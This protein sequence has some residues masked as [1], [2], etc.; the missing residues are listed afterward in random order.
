MVLLPNASQ[1][2]PV[3]LIQ[4]TL[5]LITGALYPVKVLSM[6]ITE[7][8]DVSRWSSG[9]RRKRRIS[10]PMRRPQGDVPLGPE[11]R[12][13]AGSTCRGCFCLTTVAA[14][15]A[16]VA[17]MSDRC[18]YV[19]LGLLCLKS[20]V[21]IRRS[22]GRLPPRTRYRGT[23]QTRPFQLSGRPSH[24]LRGMRSTRGH[25]SNR[26][27]SWTFPHLCPYG[28]FDVAC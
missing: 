22:T 14:R 6:G 19:T 8:A 25:T 7:K 18:G 26:R 13:Q 10:H 9:F 16:D 27:P 20:R 24:P 5:S 15:S 28:C 4:Q 11:E 12:I 2:L 3:L 21:C 23:F 17:S 1:V